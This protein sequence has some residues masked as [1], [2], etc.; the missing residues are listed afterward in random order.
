[1]INSKSGRLIYESLWNIVYF[2]KYPAYFSWIVYGSL[3]MIS[4]LGFLWR[5]H[6]ADF[7]ANNVEFVVVSIA[8]RSVR[9]SLFEAINH[10]TANFPH[11]PLYILIDQ[12]SELLNELEVLVASHR[13]TLVRDAQTTDRVMFKSSSDPKLELVIVPKEYRTD[14]R[15]K[16]RAMNFF[17]ENYVQ[18]NKWYCFIDDDN[19]ILDDAFLYEIPY[20]E[21]KGYALCNL[22]IITR[23]G[24]SRF[25]YVMDNMRLFDDITISRLY[26]GMLH[27]PLIGLHGEGLTVKGNVLKE[28]G[29]GKRTITEDFVFGNEVVRRR[30]KNENLKTWVSETKIS[31]KSAYTLHDFLRQRAR[32]FKGV[33][34]DLKDTEP[35]VK[36]VVGIRMALWTVNLFG[37]WAFSPLWIFWVHESPLWFY[38]FFLG[39]V[40]PWVVFILYI[41]KFREF[42]PWYFSFFVP[43][44]GILES[45]I[46]WYVLF[47][48]RKS[49]SAF[50]VIDKS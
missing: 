3:L 4:F 48:Q 35:V 43:V 20:Y 50:V 21:P 49:S 23:R 10:T 41:R 25:I 42:Q 36:I 47:Q 29:Y 14:L 46:A 8:S 34:I 38:L 33:A 13:Q 24:K 26:T 7:A 15:G 2:L 27:I 18:G 17:I 45:L 5:P 11:I 28:I 16:G 39:G 6:R 19:L 40:T 22:S 44:Y 31:I 1:M 32:W 30:N 37:S 9:A 12:R